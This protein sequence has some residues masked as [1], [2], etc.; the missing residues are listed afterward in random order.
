MLVHLIE[1]EDLS[2]TIDEK[3]NIH[4][5]PPEISYIFF[6]EED[7]PE[8]CAKRIYFNEPNIKGEENVLKYLLEY[9]EDI[10]NTTVKI[11]IM[12]MLNE[13]YGDTSDFVLVDF[14]F[15]RGW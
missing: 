11:A 8:G 12:K 4:L 3:L 1:A 14:P 9:Q 2:K 13:Q 6:P 7:Y 5:R 10:Q 15:E